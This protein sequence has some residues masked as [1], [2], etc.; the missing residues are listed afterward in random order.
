MHEIAVQDLLQDLKGLAAILVHSGSPMHWQEAAIFQA[1]HVLIGF[2][3][4]CV[5]L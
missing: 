3:E 5:R 1:L 4:G 2:L